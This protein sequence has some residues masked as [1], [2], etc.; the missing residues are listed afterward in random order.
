VSRAALLAMLRDIGDSA[1]RHSVVGGA[2]IRAGQK[3]YLS[4]WSSRTDPL[5][6]VSKIST[7]FPRVTSWPSHTFGPP[8]PVKEVAGEPR[9]A[10]AH[11]SLVSLPV[12]P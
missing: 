4:R 12:L 1:H 2:L 10:D 7:P 11:H 9:F 5:Q 3:G 8:P 6:L